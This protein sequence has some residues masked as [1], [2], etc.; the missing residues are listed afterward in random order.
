MSW[1]VR[2]RLWAVKY[3]ELKIIKLKIYFYQLFSLNRV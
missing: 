3:I 2:C 1:K